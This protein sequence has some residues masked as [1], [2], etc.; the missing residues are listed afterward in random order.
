MM[1]YLSTHVR[2]PG[3]AR[4]N[5]IQG[6]VVVRF[7]V[8]QNG[9]LRDIQ[10]LGRVPASSLTAEAVRVIK[11]MPGTRNRQRVRVQYAVPIRFVLQ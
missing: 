9:T 8:Q 10:V 5:G 1:R 4:K 7:I 11:G 6:A 3:D 2:Y